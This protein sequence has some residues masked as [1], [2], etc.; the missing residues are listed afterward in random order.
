MAGWLAESHRDLQFPMK[1]A[2]GIFALA[3][4]CLWAAEEFENPQTISA[5]FVQPPVLLKGPGWTV[6]PQV[7]MHKFHCRYTV[8]SAYGTFHPH[9]DAEFYETLRDIEAI[10]VLRKISGSKVFSHSFGAAAKMPLQ[11][12][13]KVIEHPVDSLAALPVNAFHMAQLT[14]SRFKEQ[15]SGTPQSKFEDA[16]P[17]E[18]LGFSDAKRQLAAELGVDPYTANKALQKELDKLAFAAY[19]GQMSISSLLAM[20]PAAAFTV[21]VA[22]LNL[23]PEMENRITDNSVTDLRILDRR[24]LAALGVPKA[25]SDRFFH[26]SIYSPARA[27]LLVDALKRMSGVEGLTGYVDLAATA[28]KQVDAIFYEK[29]AQMLAVYHQT[30][31]PLRKLVM[32]FD[33]PAAVT[34]DGRLVAFLEYDYVWWTRD[35]QQVVATLRDYPLPGGVKAPCEIWISGQFSPLARQKLIAMGCTPFPRAVQELARIMR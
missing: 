33:T 21:G 4:P 29:S 5:G 3:A 10:A 14:G 1:W 12:V 26:A 16:V 17:L 7:E 6:A 22:G 19:G 34:Q 18:V 30:V 8:S 28:K 32:I 2:V 20:I 35:A 31:R 9:C 25:S 24:D 15:F 11:A 13:G 27:S 23:S